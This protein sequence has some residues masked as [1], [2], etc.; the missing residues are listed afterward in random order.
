MA[1]LSKACGSRF[2]ASRSTSTR[3]TRSTASSPGISRQKTTDW[4]ELAG[5]GSKLEGPIRLIGPEKSTRGGE[6]LMRQAN[7]WFAQPTWETCKSDGEIIDAVAKDPMALGFASLGLDNGV[8][9]LGLRM[10]RNGP[11][12]LPSLDAIEDERYGLAKVIYVYYATPA[13]ATTQAV[14]DCLF[15]SQGAAAIQATNV[16]PVAK[17]RAKIIGPR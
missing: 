5:P 3:S 17:D 10:D 1:S 15:S 16:W 9:Y 7:I 4:K 11:P 13:S 8:R 14:L 12:V 2:T 6:L